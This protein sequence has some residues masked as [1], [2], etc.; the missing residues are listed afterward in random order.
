MTLDSNTVLGYRICG[1]SCPPWVLRGIKRLLQGR[2][3]PPS[4][5][6]CVDAF[7]SEIPVWS[8]FLEGL[9]SS[10]LSRNRKFRP[11]D[12]EVT[13]FRPPRWRT[14][15]MFQL[16]LHLVIW[17][18]YSHLFF[19]WHPVCGINW[20]IICH[21]GGRKWVTSKSK[22]RNFRFLDSF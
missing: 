11:T 3:V 18:F 9:V 6:K 13:H 21:L 20:N 15:S 5:G 14:S 12:F 8:S 16:Q 1:L 2:Y 10:K 19:L 4:S 22:G 17:G 7:G